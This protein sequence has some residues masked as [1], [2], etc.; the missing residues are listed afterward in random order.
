V[1]VACFRLKADLP[2]TAFIY[3]V[4]IVSLSLIGSYFAS[5]VLIVMAVAGSTELI[6]AL[7]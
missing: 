1:T 7:R 6:D 4:V 3:L 5:V 2:T